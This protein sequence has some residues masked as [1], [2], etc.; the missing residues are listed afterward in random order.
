MIFMIK[1]SKV[2]LI[3]W[4]YFQKATFNLD[5]NAAIVG[6]NGTGKSTIIDAIQ[7]LILGNKASHFNANANAEK[8]TLES[9]VRGA[10][11]TEEKDYLRPG[12]VIT[13]LA[14]EVN[15]NDKKHILGICMEYKYNLSKLSDPRYFYLKEVDLCENLFIKDSYPISY[16]EFNKSNKMLL[17]EHFI[18][19]P[20]LQA[21]QG[22][23]KDILGLKDEKK[24]FQ[25][26]SRA[27]GIK[28]IDDCNTFMNTFVLDESNI[29]VSSIKN[30][31]LEM[32]KISKTI[33]REQ[34]KLDILTEI[35]EKGS[36]V[37]ENINIINENTNKIN[38]ANGI[39]ISREIE[40]LELEIEMAQNSITSIDGE[41][42]S[43]EEKR[44]KYEKSKDE[45]FK[46]LEQISPDLLSKESELEKVEVEHYNAKLH[47]NTFKTSCRN[48]IASLIELKRYNNC[49]FNNFV[50]FL[51]KEEYTT[52]IAKNEFLTFRKEAIDLK[53]KYK[54][55]VVAYDYQLNEIR[56]QLIEL[57]EMIKQ[58]ENNTPVYEPK[59]I[60][61]VEYLKQTLYDKYH[62]DIEVKFLCDYLDITNNEWRNA[63]EG[64][65]DKQRFYIVVPNE[66][67][68]DAIKLYNEKKDFYATKIINGLRLPQQDFKEGTLGEFITATNSIALNYA[69]YLLNR[70]HYVADVSEL[71]N[72]NIAITKECMLYQGFATGRI[73]PKIYSVQYIGTEGI[74]NQLKFRRHQFEEVNRQGNLILEKR[75]KC[76]GCYNELESSVKFVSGIIENNFLI[77]SIDLEQKLFERIEQLTEEIQFYKS[78]PQYID[79]SNKISL[80]EKEIESINN[81]L[82]LL[83]NDKIKHLTKIGTNKE[84]VIEKNKL[85]D[86][87]NEK[88]SCL[89]EINVLAIKKELESINISF[90]YIRTLESNNSYLEKTNNKLILEI[91]NNMAIARDTFS[92][93][94]APNFNSLSIFIDEKN[95]INQSIFNYKSKI[96][97]MKENN[98]KLFFTQF[99]TKLNNSINRAKKEIDSLNYSLGLFRFGNDKY[100]IKMSQSSNIDLQII[101]EYAVK[102][103][104]SE[105]ERGLFNFD[106]QDIE[107]EKIQ[108]IL[109]QYMFSEDVKIQQLIIDYRNYLHFDV[110]VI[111]PNGTK[112][113]NKVIKSQS[114]GE[115]QVPFYI[116]TG[117]AFQ[118]TLDYKRR[119]DDVLG[120]VLFDEAFD[121]MDSQRINSMLT[122]YREKLNIQLI[123][124]TPGKLESLVD[125]LETIVAV[126]RDGETAIV[127]DISHELR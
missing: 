26:L 73:N 59:L 5:G 25:I 76:N 78:N 101:Y 98:K 29:D 96:I 107:R 50:S 123:I 36:R 118:Q 104:E 113:L 48:Q 33:E 52:T 12:D 122:F 115:V 45:L 116:L 35:A 53:E 3:N 97:N 85:K 93:N 71:D 14:M 21:Y 84:K 4:M 8:R 100:K 67:Y 83:T 27:V 58:L 54:E 22:K 43:L 11:L 111:T 40:N 2:V 110:E 124:A 69:R 32:E 38:V 72:F 120:I 63:I 61:F 60:Q 117:V 106:Q 108:K 80:V 114:G 17:G 1:V 19:F 82:S 6:V 15:F 112:S 51:K 74:K 121:K 16:S 57:Q 91:E 34:L 70:V 68:R 62:K 55:K 24:Y 65:L 30:N 95:K 75:N 49:Y 125:N 23:I 105:L 28:N 103:S 64:Y 47:L 86:Q 77:D 44:K 92:I 39:L 41:M 102:Y 89:E 42:Q 18:T 109:N 9:Y 94:A 13:Y 10:V 79:I 7:M 31:I 20:T 56:E 81:T 87:Y 127:S 119:N 66:Y 99:L 88:N 90:S 37:N 126:I 46:M